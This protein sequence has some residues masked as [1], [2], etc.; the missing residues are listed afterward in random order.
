M[1]EKTRR[2]FLARLIGAA[3]G[4][5]ALVTGWPMLRSL[6]PNV[7]AKQK[8]RDAGAY[9]AWLVDADGNV[10][11]GSSSNAWIVTASG[12]L[13]TRPLGKEILPG[14][15]RSVVLEAAGELQMPVEER[16]FS[17]SEAVAASEAFLTS[18]SAILLPIVGIDGA[19]VGGGI[20]GPVARRLRAAAQ[21]ISEIS[22]RQLPSI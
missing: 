12:T 1:E 9:E 3:L 8:A 15:S 18:S 16:A 21:G 17:I 7:L 5:G 19:P 11:E 20:S 2:T 22:A 4:G 6:L 13:V 10:T 14:I